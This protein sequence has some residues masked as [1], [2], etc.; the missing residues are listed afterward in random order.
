MA[1]RS[2]RSHSP[3]FT[4]K[5]ALAAIKGERAMIE[6]AQDFDVHP[7]Q[8]KPWRDQVLEGATRVFGE[9]PKAKPEPTIDVKTPHAKIGE[10][11]LENE[12]LSGAQRTAR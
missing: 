5:V 9:A 8:I 2:R 6:L 1:R 12:L 3:A 7:N 11:T 10:L 4:A